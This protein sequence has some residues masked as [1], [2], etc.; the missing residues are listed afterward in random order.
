[1]CI[2]GK[3]REVEKA[4]GTQ[5]MK[6]EVGG[7]QKLDYLPLDHFFGW[8]ERQLGFLGCVTDLSH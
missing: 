8:T 6:I 7:N 5:K 3:G 1:M 4:A 2:L